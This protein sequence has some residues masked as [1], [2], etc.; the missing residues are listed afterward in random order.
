MGSQTYVREV[1]WNITKQLSQDNIRF[2]RKLSDP[3][4]LSKVPFSSVD[5]I[6]DLDIS[7]ECNH[8][9]INYFQ[10]LIGVLR[11]IVELDRIDIVY[12]VS[13][14]SKFLAWPR[15]GHIYQVLHISRI[16][17]YILTMIC[18]LIRFIKKFKVLEILK[19]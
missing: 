6:L 8:S 14:L 13:S 19:L 16:Y 17:R 7:L 1:I 15:T 10:N 12:E 18:L 3:N 9:H 5:Y 11:W 4:Y 2:N